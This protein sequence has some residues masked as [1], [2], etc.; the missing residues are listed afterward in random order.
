MCVGNDPCVIPCP[1][2][3][4]SDRPLT[5]LT[6]KRKGCDTLVVSIKASIIENKQILP[7]FYQMKLDAHQIAKEAKPGQFVMIKTSQ[8]LDPFLKRP[9]SLHR[10][11]KNAGTIEL[12]YQVLGKGTKLL[13]ELNPGEPLEIMGPLG[14]GFTWQE[15]YKKVAI[16]GGGCGIAPLL[17]LAE[18]L[19]EAGK[20][21][22]VLL[23]AQNKDR[24]LNETQFLELGCKVQI[25]TDDGSQGK[26]GFVTE[27]LAE[28]VAT[29][30]IYQVYCCGPLPMTRGVMKITADKKIPCQVSLEERMAC[31][32]GACLGCVC[33]VRNEN[34]TV[35]NKRVCHDGPVFKGSEILMG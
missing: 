33:Q 34:G 21:V 12:I 3:P 31:G 15:D 18:E 7:D 10:I 30:N 1:I 28:L 25:A 13:S 2:N 20:E 16:V 22:H 17:A 14:N 8:A 6:R 24:L 11:N 4:T 29:S 26:K 23:G 5:P 9:I 19:K 35:S 32:I 27:L